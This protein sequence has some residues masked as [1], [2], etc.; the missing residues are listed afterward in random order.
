[1]TIRS[2]YK[3]NLLKGG[4]LKRNTV[5]QV[6]GFKRFDKVKYEN[7]EYFVHGLRSSGYFDIRDLDGNKIGG[8]VNCRKLQLIEHAKG[9]I[10]E[11]RAIP[12]RTKVQSLLA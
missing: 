8:S 6:N 2:L 9:I 12:L 3:A 10:Q 7:K 11:V 4:R 5:K 1:M